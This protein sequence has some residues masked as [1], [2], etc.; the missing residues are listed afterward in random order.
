MPRSG[1]DRRAV[2]KMMKDIQR[3]FDKHPIRVPVE[4]DDPKIPSGANFGTSIYNGPVIQ[5]TST[6]HSWRG[7]TKP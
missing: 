7:T 5:G 2:A 1:I 4:V 6:E 3:E